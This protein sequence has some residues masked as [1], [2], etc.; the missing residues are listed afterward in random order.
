[1]QGCWELHPYIPFNYSDKNGPQEVLKSYLLKAPIG[2]LFVLPTS[3]IRWLIILNFMLPSLSLAA[4]QALDFSAWKQQKI[5]AAKQRYDR[6]LLEYQAARDANEDEKKKKAR[7]ARRNY[8]VLRYARQLRVSD[9][10][11]LY[12]MDR[13][14]NDNNK[15]TEALESLPEA[16]K[17]QFMAD[18]RYLLKKRD[19]DYFKK[20]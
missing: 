7:L 11:E 19:K 16:Q 17:R 9:Y 14:P 20:Q 12:L 3:M 1:M 15:L 5:L 18:Y 4:T 6:S 10:F 8:E 2:T 13:Y